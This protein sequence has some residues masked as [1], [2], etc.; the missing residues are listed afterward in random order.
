MMIDTTENLTEMDA[1]EIK[2]QMPPSWLID[3]LR[4]KTATNDHSGARLTAVNWLM[5]Q[6]RANGLTTADQLYRTAMGL[7]CVFESIAII[8]AELGSLPS[9][10]ADLRWRKTE[11]LIRLIRRL[12]PE[13]AEEI[14][15]AM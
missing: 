6:L 11:E 10:V 14:R 9:D 12:N 4:R 15:K 3:Q 2:L 8:H 7:Y 1:D 13:A 5:R